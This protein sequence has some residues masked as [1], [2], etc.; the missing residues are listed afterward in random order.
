MYKRQQ[1]PLV[2]GQ[3]VGKIKRLLRIKTIQ[4][5]QDITC[6]LY[7]STVNDLE[8][9]NPDIYD[10]P[11]LTF[12]TDDGDMNESI[13]Y[14]GSIYASAWYNDALDYP[15]EDFLGFN[16]TFYLDPNGEVAVSYTHLDV[17]KRQRLWRRRRL[18]SHAVPRYHHPG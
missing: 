6:L 5:P 3:H 9:K 8:V 17:Y 11:Y 4:I 18:C 12:E 7:T 16:Y 14:Q 1:R 15:V 2:N 10:A 13:F